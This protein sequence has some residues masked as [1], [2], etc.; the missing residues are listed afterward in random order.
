[1]NTFKPE[2][3]NYRLS[4]NCVGIKVTNSNC[5]EIK[6]NESYLP[7][8][9]L[10]PLGKFKGKYD[11]RKFRCYKKLCHQS[12]FKNCQHCKY[13]PYTSSPLKNRDYYCE[14]IEIREPELN[15]YQ[16][17][18]LQS[19]AYSIES[20]LVCLLNGVMDDYVADQKDQTS[21]L[22]LKSENVFLD[23]YS[24][25]F[26]SILKYA[27]TQQIEGANVDKALKHLFKI[28]N[29]IRSLALISSLR[30]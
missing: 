13:L 14:N 20:N 10:I 16:R 17:E 3:L 28:T 27:S 29:R 1:M 15:S 26:P 5:E 30:R 19:D 22:I 2:L 8:T 18:K 12:N 24:I 4:E 6:S 7:K 21:S 11:T 23:Y 25:H 9:P